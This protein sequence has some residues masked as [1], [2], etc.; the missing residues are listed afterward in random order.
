MLRHKIK[1]LVVLEKGRPVGMLSTKDFIK[2]MIAEGGA[3]GKWRPIDD[4]PVLRIIS[5]KLITV[6]PS[7]HITKAA[8]LMLKH[9]ISGIPIMKNDEL[10]GVLTKTDVTRY[11]ASNMVGKAK[12]ME[13]MTGKIIT[14]NRYHSLRHIL[15]LMEQN[16]VGRIVIADGEKPIGIVTTTDI[17][18]AQLETPDVGA[19]Q[20]MVKFTRKAERAS[21]PK[22]RYVKYVSVTAEN[23]MKQE[24]LTISA[25]ED[26]A[27]A[28]SIMLENGIS[29][30]PVVKDDK[31][32]GIITKTDIVRKV[33]EMSD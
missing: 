20:Q 24:L 1:H 33:A 32:I 14:A 13:L 6:D 12:V 10:V 27:E 2:A 31:L 26:A 21:R 5:N 3:I 17:L 23:I 22:Y 25:D 28:A 19:P 18:F 30:L 7:T 29:G 16:N 11:F 4:F 9:G 15:E 8:N